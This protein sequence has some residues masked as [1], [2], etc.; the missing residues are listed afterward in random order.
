MKRAAVTPDQ[1]SNLENR[2]TAIERTVEAIKRDVEGKDYKPSLDKL[3]EALKDTHSSLTDMMP[4]IF[5]EIVTGSAPRIG[6]F[7]FVIIGF[8]LLLV[9]VYIWYKR[10]RANAPKKYL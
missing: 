9:G 6:F 7:V 3:H 10:R 4:H 5:N 8:Q 2:L 1:I